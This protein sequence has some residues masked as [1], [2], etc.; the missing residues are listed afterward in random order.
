LIAAGGRTWLDAA[1]TPAESA[2]NSHSQGHLRTRKK[3]KVGREVADDGRVYLRHHP[4]LMFDQ[5]QSK[6]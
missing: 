2:R 5:S 4:Q 1:H 6:E 3:T